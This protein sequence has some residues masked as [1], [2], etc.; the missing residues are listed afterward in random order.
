MIL[1]NR[2]K[3]EERISFSSSSIVY[4]GVDLQ[5]KK[6]VAIKKV[7]F[8]PFFFD[9]ELTTL[10][11]LNHKAVIK[12]VDYFQEQ[13]DFYLITQ[14]F[15]GY[16]LSTGDFL[17]EEWVEVF[18]EIAKGLLYIHENG[19]SHRDLKPQNILINKNKEV[20]IIDFGIS[21]FQKDLDE[22][23]PQ[24]LGTLPY[25]APEQTGYLQK[26]PDQR[27]D[28]YSLGVIFYECL[29]GSNPFYA[30]EKSEIIHKHL[31]LTPK[32]I[33]EM[34]KSNRPKILKG[35]SDIIEKMLEKNSNQRYVSVDFIVQDL[36]KLLSVKFPL[37]AKKNAVI[38]HQNLIQEVIDSVPSF[39]LSDQKLFLIKGIFGSGKSFIFKKVVKN[40]SLSR[41]ILELKVIDLN[42][43]SFIR[44][45]LSQLGEDSKNLEK[46]LK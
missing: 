6:P 25:M 4:K 16:P 45:L 28:I 34:I 21:I 40:I 43:F 35:I 1:K 20:K 3:I 31:S 22:K 15:S 32:P 26:Q 17:L 8:H 41:P 37:Q 7:N 38:F 24:F 39:L 46:I 19:I 11:N 12:L 9:A 13:K 5:E 10:K 33:K 44:Q 23:D 36:E 14:W 2:Y 29:V 27:S 18:L 30:S 42:P